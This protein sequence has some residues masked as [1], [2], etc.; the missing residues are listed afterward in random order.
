MRPV[1]RL[2]TT[3][4]IVVPSPGQIIVPIEPPINDPVV[5]T[6]WLIAFCL[7]AVERFYP[8]IKSIP[9]PTTNELTPPITFEVT[10]DLKALVVVNPTIYLPTVFTE[11]YPLIPIL[12]AAKFSL[13]LTKPIAVAALVRTVLTP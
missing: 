13:I 3:A 9:V 11:L 12:F 1:E 2:P 7:T 10:R 6:P 4:P 8:L 5:E